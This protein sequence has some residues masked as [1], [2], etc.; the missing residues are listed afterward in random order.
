MNR[1]S[2]SVFAGLCALTLSS[3]CMLPASA[4]NSEVKEKPPMYSYISNWQ[5]PRAH[6]ADMVKENDADKPT[7]DKALADGTIVAYG[8]DE[9]Y[10]HTPEGY[11]HDEWWSSMS[12]A[13]LLN[14]L[15]TFYTSG[16]VDTPT[17]ESATKHSDEIVVSR[18]YNWHSGPY[19]NAPLSV[20]FY[21]L[22]ADAP[23]D[24]VALLSKSL[25]VPLMEKLLADG[26]IVE[27]E[28][29]TQ[30]IHTATPGSFT[31]VWIPASNEGVDKVNAALR[32]AM[33]AQPLGGPA[34]LSMIDWSKHRDELWRGM[35]VYK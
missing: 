2:C 32:D 3:L 21:Q 24:A 28:I 7:M 19:K 18:F 35:G 6:W 33:K 4:Q 1:R 34:F 26:T 9:N 14:V 8:S 15:D 10:V 13:G 31:I 27:Y 25:I 29:D 5:I 17:L 11:T 16:S 12:M 22:K 30:A 20:A 23:D